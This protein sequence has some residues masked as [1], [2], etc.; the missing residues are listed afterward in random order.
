MTSPNVRRVAVSLCVA[1]LTV[2]L[3]A[4]GGSEPNDD[5]TSAAEQTTAETTAPTMTD[6][7]RVAA[8]EAAVVGELPDAP[9]WEGL[10]VKGVVVDDTAV[11]VDRTYRE[12][13]GIDG[14]G[15]NA[16]YVVVTFPGATTGEPKDGTCAKSAD[17]STA[18]TVAGFPE[19]FSTC[20]DATGDGS[21]GVDITEVTVQND[22]ALV[23]AAMKLA[24]PLQPSDVDE[25]SFLTTAYSADGSIG[26]Q[27]GTKFIGGAEAAN[28]VFD[29]GS[30]SQ[31][32]VTNGA[33][34]ADGQIAVRYPVALLEDLGAGFHWSTAVTL[35]GQDVDLCGDDSPIVTVPEG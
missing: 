21:G 26:Y 22:G 28:F 18:P 14:K 29:F 34:F 10:T 6:A 27:F 32:N 9:I 33:V 20:E 8:A 1:A 5:V 3:A 17:L 4:C 23:S 19:F 11:C 2:A 16:G 25:L 13:G 35:N 31:E 15:G 24:D 30:A 12:G 7:E